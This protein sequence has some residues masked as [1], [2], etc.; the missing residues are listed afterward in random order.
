M[1]VP[2]YAPW[3]SF[4]YERMLKSMELAQ[5]LAARNPKK[6]TQEELDAVSSG[7]NQALNTMRPG[8]LAELEDLRNLTSLLQQADRMVSDKAATKELR[9][10]IMYGRMVVKYVTDGSGTKD[11][12]KEAERRLQNHLRVKQNK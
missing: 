9:D 6:V 2:E 7:L 5:K 8:N 1:K 10:A 12:I 3:A 11:F 4:G